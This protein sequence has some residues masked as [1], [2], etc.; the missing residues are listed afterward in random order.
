MKFP[1]WRQNK[2]PDLIAYVCVC[3]WMTT[4]ETLRDLDFQCNDGY[5]VQGKNCVT[6][7]HRRSIIGKDICSNIYCANNSDSNKLKET[8]K[9]K[10]ILATEQ[11]QCQRKRQQKK[12]RGIDGSK[13]NG[14]H[15]N[16]KDIYRN[17]SSN[18][19][20]GVPV[21]DTVTNTVSNSL[22]LDNSSAGSIWQWIQSWPRYNDFLFSFSVVVLGITFN[23]LFLF[24]L[25]DILLMLMSIPD[26]DLLD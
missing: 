12:H 3:C 8:T 9:T 20:R 7:V 18:S 26:D 17:R 6:H 2:F 19:D 24:S 10:V 1:P 4:V 14:S 16:D 15:K 21:L 25:S 23:I 11:R 22:R 13:D 5:Y